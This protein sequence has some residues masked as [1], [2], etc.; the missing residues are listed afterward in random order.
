MKEVAPLTADDI[1]GAP[2]N[3]LF[4]LTMNHLAGIIGDDHANWRAIIATLPRGYGL[5]NAIGWVDGEVNNGGFALYFHNTDGEPTMQAL[6]GYAVIG[7]PEHAALLREATRIAAEEPSGWLEEARTS[8]QAYVE[9]RR[10]TKLMDLDDV[11]YELE[12]SE[13]IFKLMDRYIRSHPEDF[14]PA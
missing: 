10:K 12:K 8:E 9:Y 3:K 11:Y 14:I 13:D 5:I 4:D 6:K 2:S 7:A 1:A